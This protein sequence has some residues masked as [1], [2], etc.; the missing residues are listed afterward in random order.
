MSEEITDSTPLAA[1]DAPRFVTETTGGMI[2]IV[3]TSRAGAAQ[4][5]ASYTLADHMSALTMCERLNAR[6]ANGIEDVFG[7]SALIPPLAV[8]GAAP[9][10]GEFLAVTLPAYAKRQR[11]EALLAECGQIEAEALKMI[12]EGAE[13]LNRIIAVR[14]RLDA[15]IWALRI[16]EEPETLSGVGTGTP[17]ASEAAT[18]A[19]AG[20]PADAIEEMT[21][22]NGRKPN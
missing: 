11:A 10:P 6:H 15:R 22:A 7:G 4:V 17:E 13:I 3:D 16:T 1:N 2:L 5:V 18:A 20:L 14:D 9:T 19:L 8:P 21:R 12:R